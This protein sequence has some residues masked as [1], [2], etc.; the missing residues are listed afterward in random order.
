MTAK[1]SDE[2][3]RAID[4]H[5]GRPVEVE[6]PVTHKMYVLIE[7]PTHARAMKALEQQKVT[8]SIQAGIDDMEAGRGMP[9]E[10]A[11]RMLRKKLGFPKNDEVSRPHQK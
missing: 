2:L 9:I 6:H 4:A 5:Q 8:R 3:Q 10:A 1:L 11:D 7:Q